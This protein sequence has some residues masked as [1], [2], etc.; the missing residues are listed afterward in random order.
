M[1]YGHIHVADG[2][3]IEK[4]VMVPPAAFKPMAEVTESIIDPA[5]EPHNGPPIA[6]VE[7]EPATTPSPVSWCPEE[8][9]FRG[10]HPSTRHPVI[11]IPVGVPSPIPGRPDIVLTWA[12][13]LIVYR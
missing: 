3:I 2:S 8:S 7:D 11:I 10:Q 12:D 1:D 13:R 6:V 4:V 5:V 9:N